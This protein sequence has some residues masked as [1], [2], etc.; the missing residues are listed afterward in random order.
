MLFFY[1]KKKRRRRIIVYFCQSYKCSAVDVIRVVTLYDE[2]K[3]LSQLETKSIMIEI[4]EI[5]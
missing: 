5:Q 1:L 3:A 2:L 4:A